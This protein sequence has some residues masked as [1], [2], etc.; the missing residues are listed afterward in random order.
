M[1]AF[2]VDPMCIM[3]NNNAVICTFLT[4]RKVVAWEEMSVGL[5]VEWLKMQDRK[6]EDQKWSKGGKYRAGKRGIKCPGCIFQPHKFRCCTFQSCISPPPSTGNAVKNA[7]CTMCSRLNCRISMFNCVASIR[8]V[9]STD[10]YNTEITIY[11]YQY[12]I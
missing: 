4:N 10:L 11:M 7:L 12:F 9:S 5:Q 2:T 1:S 6:M 8:C 3:R